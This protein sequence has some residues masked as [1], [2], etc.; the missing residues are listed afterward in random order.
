MPSQ[1]RYHLVI[2]R[3]EE[4]RAEV[5]PLESVG[6]LT[7]SVGELKKWRDG[8]PGTVAQRVCLRALAL[9][10]NR[11]Q[12]FLNHRSGNSSKAGFRVGVDGMR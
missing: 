9:H 2:L 6:E 11:I 4:F 8:C 3:K 12:L 5:T 10:K 7:L 1:A